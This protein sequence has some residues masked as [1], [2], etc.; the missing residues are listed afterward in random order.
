[1][2]SHTSVWGSDA[3]NSYTG[4]VRFESCLRQTLLTSEFRGFP[5]S[6]QTNAGIVHQFWQ[7]WILPNPSPVR[8]SFP[9]MTLDA[10]LF[11]H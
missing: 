8:H 11:C 10:V 2:Y 7:D 1:M 9:V 3:R 5:P 6:F 4:G